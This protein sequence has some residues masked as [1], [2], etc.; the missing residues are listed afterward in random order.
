MLNGNAYLLFTFRLHSIAHAHVRSQKTQTLD[1]DL[2]KIQ[3]QLSRSRSPPS[4]ATYHF[5]PA[6]PRRYR[7]NV[8]DIERQQ[9][10]FLST[11]LVLQ[12]ERCVSPCLPGQRL[13]KKMTFGWDIYF[14]GI[15]WPYLG[16]VQRSRSYV[17][18][19][20]CSQNEMC[21]F[22]QWMHTTRW[23]EPILAKSIIWIWNSK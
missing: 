19:R 11:T 12:V 1:S 18:Q 21:L 8:K 17:G 13:S 9:Q 5:T 6:L 14:D 23:N 3:P 4:A 22:R 15:S 20:S 2:A 16:Q 10:L 7:Y